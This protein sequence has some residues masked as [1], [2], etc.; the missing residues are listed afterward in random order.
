MNNSFDCGVKINSSCLYA[1]LSLIFHYCKNVVN[2]DHFQIATHIID[3]MCLFCIK[4]A[5]VTP[6]QIK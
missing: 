5:I 4:R 1:Q 6:L 2:S 3:S